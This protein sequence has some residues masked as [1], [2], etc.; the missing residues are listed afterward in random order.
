MRR[1]AALLG[2][3]LVLGLGTSAARA[4]CGSC[5]HGWYGPLYRLYVGESIPYFA[6]HPPVYYSYPV[7][8]TY[9]YSP[10]AYPPGVMTPEVQQGP[11]VIPNPHAAPPVEV[12]N[13]DVSHQTAQAPHRR[14]NPYVTTSLA[15]V[16]QTSR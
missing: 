12:P 4:D 16:S 6:L 14:V 7:P 9:G 1:L 3:T 13:K 15:E 8:R 5:G 11:V 10:W 2:V